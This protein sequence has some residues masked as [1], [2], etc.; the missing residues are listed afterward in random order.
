L[1]SVERTAATQSRKMY[2]RDEAADD[3][4][5]DSGA[6]SHMSATGEIMINLREI[7]EREILTASMQTL[8]CNS[9]GDVDIVLYDEDGMRTTK[10]TMK[11]VLHV[12]GLQTN[13]LSCRALVN[14]VRVPTYTYND[15]CIALSGRVQRHLYCLARTRAATPVF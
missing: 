8:V 12:P 9:M 10:A 13:L 15:T 7:P 11:D 1:N 3:F 5:I 14:A 2:D 4:L 6:S